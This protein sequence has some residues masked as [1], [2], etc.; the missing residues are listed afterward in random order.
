MKTINCNVTIEYNNK[1]FNFLDIV[2]T[3]EQYK[4]LINSKKWMGANIIKI[5]KLS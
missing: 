4:D 2:F 5:E 1:K 3:A